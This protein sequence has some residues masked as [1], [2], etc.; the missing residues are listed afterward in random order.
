MLNMLQLF[1]L[2]SGAHE[3]VPV[4][5]AGCGRIFVFGTGRDAAS[6]SK[7]VAIFLSAVR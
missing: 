2:V 3:L 5:D 6:V 7:I 1:L 4:T